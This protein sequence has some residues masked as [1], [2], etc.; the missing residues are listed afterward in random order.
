MAVLLTIC[1]ILSTQAVT[2][3]ASVIPQE[4]EWLSVEDELNEGIVGAGEEA[5]AVDEAQEP[6]V[7]GDYSS[8]AEALQEVTDNVDIPEILYE[9]SID[10][11]ISEQ[12]EADEN[13]AYGIEE[14]EI[15]P[16]YAD[17]EGLE[18]IITEEEEYVGAQ[19]LLPLLSGITVRPRIGQKTTG[20]KRNDTIS[21]S[22]SYNIN[23]MMLMW[24]KFDP[25]WTYDLSSMIEDGA[26]ESISGDGGDILQ[27]GAD[28]GDYEIDGNI[29]TLYVDAMWLNRQMRGV[30]GT[31]D[32]ELNLDESKIKDADSY[33]FVFPGGGRLE[34]SFEDIKLNEN[35]AVGTMYN[36]QPTKDGSA[37][38]VTSSLQEDGSY[39]LYYQTG[40]RPSAELS[41]LGLSDTLS[42]AQKLDTSSIRV[43]GNAVPEDFISA[44]EG[45][46]SV[47]IAA[48]L[49]SIGSPISANQ[50]LNVEYQ[51]VIQAADLDTV[52]SNTADWTWVG[53]TNTATTSITPV[54]VT[55]SIDYN[56]VLKKDMSVE[57]DGAGALITYTIT[58][59]PEKIELAGFTLTDSMTDVQ[60]IVGDI[61]VT[62][63]INGSNTI[64]PTGTEIDDDTYS[65]NLK[66]VFVYTFPS[67]G[68][69]TDTYTIIYQT[70]IPET[71]GNVSGNKWVKNKIDIESPDGGKG[72]KETSKEIGLPGTPAGYELNKELTSWEADN[73]IVNWTITLDLED[74]TTLNNVKIRRNTLGFGRNQ[75]TFDIPAEILWDKITVKNKNGQDVEFVPDEGNA[76]LLF[77]TL[78][79]SVVI[80][81]AT[82]SSVSIKAQDDIWAKNAVEL[83]LGDDYITYKD[84]IGQ[85]VSDDVKMNKTVS[86]DHVR[87]EWT[88][89]VTVNP[90]NVILKSEFEPYFTDKLPEG[91]ELS[92]N[93]ISISGNGNGN[94]NSHGN[95]LWGFG[96]ENVPVSVSDGTIQPVSLVDAFGAGIYDP[97]GINGMRYVITYKTKLTAQETVGIQGSEETK[98]YSNIAFIQDGSN[99]TKGTAEKT[100]TYTY[101]FIEKFD[102]SPTDLAKDIINYHIIVNPDELTLNGGNTV[103]VTDRLSTDVELITNSVKVTDKN[104]KVISSAKAG[105]QDDSR[106]LEITIPDKTYA[107]IDFR[108]TAAKLNDPDNPGDRTEYSN[109]AI[110]RGENEHSSSTSAAHRAKEHS[111]TI[112]GTRD[113]I[114]LHKVDQY[115][116]GTDL[117][118]AVFSLYHCTLDGNYKIVGAE[119][120]EESVEDEHK[121]DGDGLAYFSGLKPYNLYYWKEETPPD[122][123]KSTSTLP[124]YFVM[125]SADED[126]SQEEA[127][128]AK[129]KEI[130]RLVQEN[131][132]FEDGSP[133]IVNTVKDQY[134]WIVTNLKDESASAKIEGSK[135]FVGRDMQDG[136]EF[137]FELMA[138]DSSYPLPEESDTVK[139][140]STDEGT[141]AVVKVKDAKDGKAK[142]FD[143]G[144]IKFE[145]DGTYTYKVKEIEPKEDPI[146]FVQYD[147]TEYD[148]TIT[149][150]TDQTTGKKSAAVVYTV[151]DNGQSAQK[152]EFGNKYIIPQGSTSLSVTKAVKGN[153][154]GSEQFAFVL[155]KVDA[156]T[157]DILPEN[158]T[159][160][161]TNGG[162]ASFDAISYS[163]KGDYYYTITEI[164]GNT[165][166]M[167]YDT[168]DKYVRVTVDTVNGELAAKSIEYGDSMEE[169]KPKL[170]GGL[171]GSSGSSLTV[172][173]TYSVI[174]IS[175]VDVADTSKELEGATLS[176]TRIRNAVGE[177]VNESVDTWT[178][179]TQAHTI[180]G[181]TNG[182]YV[183]KEDRAPLGYKIAEEITFVIKDGEIT[184]GGEG[185]RVTMSDEQFKTDVTISKV[186]L[187]Q[188]NE[189]AGAQLTLTKE[190]EETAVDSW[191]SGGGAHE[192]K[193]LTDGTYTLTEVS[194]PDG[195][196][197]AESITFTIAN[198]KLV[199][200]G[201]DAIENGVIV[202]KDEQYKGGVSVSKQ[203]LGQGTELAGASLTVTAKD[204]T[205]IDSW[206]SDGTQHEVKD[207][208]DGVYVLTETSAPEGYEIAES[209]EFTIKDG[210]L[211]EGGA[212]QGGIVTM[213][214]ALKKTDVKVSKVDAA[215]SQEL[216]GAELTVKKVKDINGNDTNDIVESWT[217]DGSIHEV[218]GL[219]D[220][221][222]T[223][224]ETSAPEGY[225]VSESITFVIKDGKLV[226][227]DNAAVQNGAVVM[228]DGL[229]KTDVKISKVDAGQSTELSGADLTVKKIKD[230]KGNDTDETV[231]SWKSTGSIHEVKGLTDG[232]YTLTETSAPQGYEVSESITFIIKDGKLVENENAKNGI[233]TMKDEQKTTTVKISKID[234]GQGKELAGAQLILTKEGQADAVDSWISDGS[235]HEVNNLTDGIYTLVEESAPDGYKKAES[236]TFTIEDGKLVENANVK[237][238][239][240]TMKDEL[241][242]GGVSISKEVLGQGKELAGAELT[243]TKIKD[244]AGSEVSEIIESWTTDGSQHE[245]ANLEDGTYVLTETSAPEGYVVAES[246]EFTIK[247]GKLVEDENAQGGVV[248]MQDALKKTDVKISKVDAGAGNELIGATLTVTRVADIDGIEVSDVIEN[249]TSDGSVHE[250]TGLTDGTYT[251][252]EESAPKG[253]KVAESITFT[254]KDGKLVE[255]ENAK[256]GIVT[257]KDEQKKTDVQISKVDA[258]AGNELKGATL[259]LT[260]EGQEEAVDSWTS[261]GTVHTVAGL[262]DGVYTLVEESAPN[263]YKKAESITFTIEDGKLVEDANVKDG[264]VTMADEQYSG[265]VSISKEVLG[266]GKELAGAVL[267]VKQIADAEGTAVSK[268]IASW[269]TDGTQKE[270]TDLED[271][272]YVLTEMSAPEGYVVAES[273]E[274]TIKNGKLVEGEN[275]QGGV[276]TMQDALK[277]TDVKISKVDAGAGNELI[278]AALTVTRVADIDGNE[279]SDVI[280]SWT[281]NGSVHEVAGLTDGTYTLVEES[282]PDGYKVAESITFVIKNGKLVEDKNAKDGIVTMKDELMKT[283]VQIS[284]V[285]AGQGNELVGAALILTKEGQ[286]ETVDKWKSDGSIHVVEGLTDGTYTLTELSAPDGYQKAESITFV[287]KDGKL[288]EDKNVINGVVTMQDKQYTGGVSVSKQALGQGTELAGASLTVTKKGETEAIE[289]WT[290]DGTLH[291]IADLEDGTY[292]LTETSAPEGYEVAESIEFTL[293]DGKLVES[294]YAKDGVVTMKDALKTT[295]VKISKVD[296]GA[297]AELKGATLTVTRIADINGNEANDLIESWTSN[298]TAHEVAGLTDGTYR[299]VEESAPNGYKVAESITFT[300]KDGKLVEDA[301]AKDGIVTMKDEL[302]RTDV[303]VSKVDAGAGNELIGAKLTVERIADAAG[304]EVIETVESWTSDGTVHEVN[305]LTDG[306]Y[307]LTE[308]SAPAGYEIAESIIFV[309]KNGK[310]VED[311]NAEDGIVTMK[312]SQK[313]TDVKISKI[314]AGAGNELAGATLTL[315][316]EG[317]DEAVDSWISDGSIH[318]V[319]GI[320]DGIYTLVEESAPDGYKKAES[321]T[322]TV[323]DGMLVSAGNDAIVD[324]VV[325]MADEQY[326]GGVSISKEVLGQGKELA[327]ADLTVTKIA[328]ASGNE[329]SELIDSWTTDGKQHEIADLADGK[330]VL[331][332]TSAPEGYEVAESIEF[333]IKDGKL[334]DG[335]D[336]SSGVVTMQDAMKKTDVKISKTDAGQ[337][338]ELIGAM[339]MVTRVMDIAGDEVND[340][341]ES[342]TSD[343]TVHE[344]TGLT[345][346][347]YTLVEESAPNGYKVAESITFTIKDG[348]LVEDENA[349]DGVVTM[350]DEQKK[351][352]VQISKV[353]AGAGNEL[354]GATLTVTRIADAAG[355]EVSEAV[356]SWIS[357]GSIHTVAGLTDGTYTLTEES[358]PDGYKVAE[359]ITFV[360]KDGKLVE[361]GN[362]AI[363]DG[364]VKMADAQ[365]KTD[366]QISKVDIG[367]GT[368]LAG[369]EL[370]V[371]R[372]ADASGKEV[373][374]VVES[375]TS[376]GSIHTVA[377][378]TDGT[379]ILTE[380]S[381]PD[382]YKKAESITFTIKDGK[383]VE[384]GNDAIVDGIVKMA[385][386]QYKGGVSISKVALGQGTEL[387]GA[388][389][390]VTKVADAAGT[391]V[392]EIVE[393]WTTDGTQ[394]DIADLADGK[395]VLTET[396]APEGYEVAES[397]EFT[398]KEGKLVDGENA[399]SGVVTMQDALKKTN[400]KVSKV[401]AG[402]GSELVG[403]ELTVTRI[404][405]IAGEEVS[406]V[407]E[408]WTSDGSVHEIEGLTD[409]TYTLVEASAPYGYEVAESITFVIK[410]GKLAEDENAADGVVTM[411]DELYRTDVQISKV[412]AGQG[413]E[414]AG[415]TLTIT[416]EGQDEAV[417]SWISDG[418]VH[419]VAGLT[420]GTYT[421]VEESAPDGYKKA[422]SITFTIKDGKL[423]EDA[424]VK[425]GIVTM[426]DE[427]Y[428]GGVS[429]SKQ[430]LGQ[431]NEL[432]GADLT[433]TRIADASGNEVNEL[434]DSWKTD[435]MQHEIADLT[436]GTYVLTEISAPEGYEVAESIVF[437]I[438]EGKL[439]EGEN[440]QGGVVTMQDAMKKTDVKISKTDAGQGN[441]LAGAT[442]TV[443]RVADIAGNE[444]NDLIESWTSDGTIHE[445]AGLTDGTYTL[446]EESAPNG[447][448]VAE[449]I[450]FTIK[451]GKLAEDENVKDGVVTMKDEQF[452]TDVKVSKVDAGQ[453]NELTGANLTVTKIADA[454]GAEVSEN[455]ASWTSDGKVHDIAGLTDGTYTLTE[456]SAPE[457]YNVAESITFVIKDGKL[458]EDANVKDGVVTMKD[459]QKKTDVQISKVDAGQGNELAG[460][461]LTITK[462]GQDEVVASWN[463]DGTVH[464]VA[465][466]TDGTYT[467]VEESAPDGYKK[468][469]SITFT[470]KDGKLVEDE[471]AKNGVVT[472][473]DELY[474]G[475]VSISKQVLGQGNELEGAEL[476]VRKIADA[477]G[478]EVD[479]K[480]DSWTSDGTQHEIADLEDGRYVLTETSAPEGYEVAE[481]I[482]FTIKNGKLVEGENAEDGVVTMLDALKKTDVK[483]SKVDAGAG[484]ELQGAELTVTRI[485][486]IAGQEVNEVVE[487]WT[488]DGIVH[489]VAG[490][491]DGTYTL[492]EE[493]APDGYKKAESITFV[494]K[495]GKLVEDA[496]AKD[497]IVTMKDERI[498]V[499]VKIIL[500]DKRTGK[501]VKGVRM[502]VRKSDNEV[503]DEWE[504][505]DKE[506]EIKELILGETY[507][508]EEKVP[509][510]YEAVDSLK[511]RVDKDGNILRLN[512]DGSTSPLGEDGIFPVN[513]TASEINFKVNKVDAGTGEEVEGADL[514]VV[515]SGQDGK[516]TVLERWT[517]KKGE[518]H[519]FGSKLEHGKK[520]LLREVTAPEGY[521]KLTTD[522]AFS[523]NEDGTIQTELATTKDADGNIVYLVENTKISVK[524]SKVDIASGAE[525]EGAK[526]RILDKDGQVIDE[527]TSTKAVHVVTGLKPGE[528]YTLSE[529]VAPT[530]YALTA[531]T[532]FVLK[533]DGSIDTTKTT[534]AVKDGVLLVQD[535]M[536]SVKVR[537]QDTDGN[538]LGGAKLKISYRNNKEVKGANWTT[539]AGKEHTITGLTAGSYYLY[540]DQAPAGYLRAARIAFDIDKYGNIIRDGKIV[541]V[542]VMTDQKITGG[543]SE[544][545]TT[546]TQRPA[547]STSVSTKSTTGTTTKAKA[548]AK[549]TGAKTG[550]N[551]P[552]M[553]YIILLV[554]AGAVIVVIKRR[555]QSNK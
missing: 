323:K 451:D 9:E 96:P 486:N 139:L 522:I 504:T 306:T 137:A 48:Y 381:A 466:L 360:I 527:W 218:N 61:T 397:I 334:V 302:F 77:E 465:G 363:V 444:V 8:E 464:T 257:M 85:Y 479:K 120:V 343:G 304:T 241:Y 7:E 355:T 232:T 92:G 130:D 490:L 483:I 182:V 408:S 529:T 497:G 426:A 181:L 203:V 307:T 283:D 433:V 164:P 255:D 178:S 555:S 317:Q 294:S 540:E 310:L 82:K 221:T 129:A 284:K 117:P 81:V 6:A 264:I 461:T 35:K 467:L 505:E 237:D 359:S 144:T 499:N 517:S 324:G 262:T 185:G 485:A 70:K 393:S 231:D 55:P 386:E 286:D 349:K 4:E 223:L 289:S 313:K 293:K 354:A 330:Y 31:F 325:V 496:N 239:I 390:T 245:I 101:E 235:I 220:G 38:D 532:K 180:A 512:E 135:T 318:V 430:V 493:T 474:K 443:T 275:A 260:K 128:E 51:T 295:D 209:I 62:P 13:A 58:V 39:R 190:G 65:E 131:N 280:E 367:A 450:T 195:Y 108:V 217:S 441:E 10:T 53:G 115:D 20:L 72:G 155:N 2:L 398:I 495:D 424:N 389:L 388:D 509:A 201:N 98:E 423:V 320:T 236:I 252:T 233:V 383:L 151:K 174:E 74:G 285:D 332:E 364:V 18:E 553:L 287:I 446:I 401:D 104:G 500:F 25:V 228:K 470:I 149:V 416:K 44:D 447:Y 84:A 422:E 501:T 40:I 93:T 47:D 337:G 60:K 542:I 127:N 91:M 402:A 434:V 347:T 431:G 152:A 167:I 240:V 372:S 311:A 226:T 225:E 404:V 107:R 469:E 179:T 210:K 463:S 184:T 282:A 437:A 21:V 335:E 484:N 457:G 189:L 159:V 43:K 342:W 67:E 102:D 136:E 429:I 80:T 160:Y 487:S 212:S 459:E 28:R 187:G 95:V 544:N 246:I 176:V 86:Y 154:T 391:E 234:A 123:Y 64:T 158:T 400:V 276:V 409:G 269:K 314:D 524:I 410:D 238:G 550:D 375:W 413:N 538:L 382:G 548:N 265:G 351:T 552:I 491:T 290:S 153:Y 361:E 171:L 533:E 1:M 42:G 166:G 448:K 537:K 489:T 259:T 525:L 148:I 22:V 277:K 224:T 111:A 521:G 425:D 387:A 395:Y 186:A 57:G 357:D 392:S 321:I 403:A 112:T 298:G 88:W 254:I 281:S 197:K 11:D 362:D 374:E 124:H 492:T 97:S 536:I 142:E 118:D 353:D 345:D 551:S 75:N 365:Y 78:S 261:D 16:E 132:V 27:G 3:W 520:Y 173:N 230:I 511:F 24:A 278:G 379:Y 421:L 138:K 30:S 100:T 5:Y 377:G 109:T 508:L 510:G 333:T 319:S 196:K 316:K 328:D 546:I 270:L 291:E 516:E 473:K 94:K 380:E 297:G 227:D 198:G 449:S 339:L 49:N 456:E 45:G 146:E 17:E 412:D 518:T 251:L 545:K 54:T 170:L 468:A 26:L 206:I 150:N 301:N 309:I 258:G 535:K 122:G 303:K 385:D 543:N 147:K 329:V 34:V 442:L 83:Y 478:K 531:D 199:T 134:T 172:T 369:A 175:K 157:S 90:G 79:E 352:D 338:G 494:I 445:I 506:H 116:L 455:V 378:L 371:T 534:T 528:T 267:E 52:E 340:L 370:T 19:S 216:A 475:G 539:E 12:E 110:V 207:L 350:K 418:T 249:W 140:I 125:Y 503:V 165:A 336:A 417:A 373:D 514:A 126:R 253:Y 271:G 33:E 272:T 432:A 248:T 407:I 488:S 41:S 322:F 394:H 99:T 299:L 68:S 312:D 194:A 292:V 162:T 476:T 200:E 46:F 523:V 213:Q 471:N 143:F 415:A 56:S 436:D 119:P 105:Y 145:N 183:L 63:A 219:V 36:R 243:V 263:G 414:L 214:D 242:S 273:I 141:K 296:A 452:K 133:V 73:D 458:V 411:K 549:T 222:Y 169:V 481:S 14:S 161:V 366:V 300:I 405:N 315:T 368:E 326:S 168:S 396:S 121:T 526:I 204:G 453:G 502:I 29:V 268:E 507:T 87:N 308:S 266:Q 462:E 515:E 229:K 274:F 208:A 482:E 358:A 69:Y 50:D 519:D 211:V 256:D 419:T 192:V 37:F 440:A 530:G 399:S 32:L 427:Q 438:I 547:S 356:D 454:A 66:E 341:I 435:G 384:E 327:G 106:E 480:V 202:M 279:V 113:T 76:A 250:V 114:A 191:T 513:I 177:E 89:T 59:N 23:D 103:T 205:G 554:A 498:K 439:F 247:D 288:V 541:S 420:D 477:S 344:I 305:G 244:A 193:G 331:T 71:T 428:K 163:E 188:N 348:R 406:E 346:G 472:M 460:A 376:D 215:D 156:N 15:L